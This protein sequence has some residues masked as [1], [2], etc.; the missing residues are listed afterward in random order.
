MLLL[1]Y[2]FITSNF[3]IMYVWQYSSLSLPIAYKISA[4]LAGQSG[5]LLFWS[6][7]IFFSSI[8]IAE[9]RKWN[10]SLVRRIQIV[11][12]FSGIF[13]VVLT[14][15]ESPFRTIYTI[16]STLP[17]DFI[18]KDGR[19][20]N[21]MLIN[22]WMAVHP[23]LVFI[24]YGLA[25]IPFASAVVH[26]L[27]GDDGWEAIGK[28]WSRIT[29]IFLTL[30]IAIGGLWAYM[31]LGWGGFWAWDP[32]ETSSLIPWITLTAYLHAASRYRKDKRS[33]AIGAP[34]LAIISMVMIVYAA[35][36]TR[37]GIFESVH[38]FG[39]SSSGTMFIVFIAAALLIVGIS[40]GKRVFLENKEDFCQKGISDTPSVEGISNISTSF[41]LTTILLSFLAFISFWGI[42]FPVLMQLF[43]DVK[44]GVGMEFFNIWG[45]PAIVLLLILLGYCMHREDNIK[46]KNMTLFVIV[47]TTILFA[48]VD[49]NPAFH[50][51]NP[52]SPFWVSQPPLYKF[53]GSISLMSIF[54]P[55]LYVVAV[56]FERMT[57]DVRSSILKPKALVRKTGI[58]II[59]IG[60]VLIL[61]GA[62]MSVTYESSFGADVQPDQIGEFVELGNGYSLQVLDYKIEGG[63]EDSISDVKRNLAS[64]PT[65]R[66]SGSVSNIQRAGMFLIFQLSDGKESIWV[67]SKEIDISPGDK[68]S[69]SG[70]VMHNFESNSTGIVYDFILFTDEVIHKDPGDDISQKVHLRIYRNGNVIGDGKAEY[71][72]YKQ[73]DVTHPM[74]DHSLTKDVYAIFQGTKSGSIPLTIKIKPFVNEVWIGVIMF[75]VG[76]VLIIGSELCFRKND[77]LAIRQK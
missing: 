49:I 32:V 44:V 67:A 52:N 61:F 26:L 45:Y 33:F 46:N 69:V 53:I 21:S 36:V 65:A 2:Y 38:A 68:V 72:Q 75:L 28:Q 13:F 54:P 19:G 6:F 9:T 73:G 25:T 55:M 18:P 74:V 66:I 3:A 41:Y 39:D 23:P 50:V 40:A 42:T 58:N 8:W 77:Y 62:I 15:M 37:S 63:P 51:M 22:P 16:D 34:F 10:S 56:I 11:T 7:M 47:V 29:W 30:A 12:I 1:A 5:T 24:A 31:A 43:R 70:G 59:H 27:T 17:L 60:V 57:G 4:V 76:M 35:L 64:Y 14:I 48:F 71:I 20:L